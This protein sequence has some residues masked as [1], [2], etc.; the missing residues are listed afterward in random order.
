MYSRPL[1]WFLNSRAIVSDAI[2]DELDR[3]CTEPEYQLILLDTLSDITI[4]RKPVGAPVTT[5]M[6][7]FIKIVDDRN[8]RIDIRCRAAF[9]IRSWDRMMN[10]IDFDAIGI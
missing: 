5:G 10:R 9:G 8:R 1:L 4:A 6:R 2:A 3:P 7:T